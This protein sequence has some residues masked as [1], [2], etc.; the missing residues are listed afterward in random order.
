MQVDVIGTFSVIGIT[1]FH[2]RSQGIKANF[3][4]AVTLSADLA[5]L[6]SL[7]H[8]QSIINIHHTH[9]IMSSFFRVFYTFYFVSCFCRKAFFF[10]WYG[11]NSCLFLYNIMSNFLSR[12]VNTHTHTPVSRP[13]WLVVSNG[14][15]LTFTLLLILGDFLY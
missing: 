13:R 3:I 6:S 11:T 5:M 1:V 14:I 9:S 7:N 2:E 10:F 8:I 15:N 4:W 12:S